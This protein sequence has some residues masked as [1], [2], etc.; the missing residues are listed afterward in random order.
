MN[1]NIIHA[2]RSDLGQKRN[3]NED[4]FILLTYPDN[5]NILVLGAIDGVG[6]YEGGEIATS[7]CKKTI[8]SYMQKPYKVLADS[9][10]KHIKKAV[11]QA[12]NTITENRKKNS[13][14][15]RMSCVVSVAFLDA[16]KERL[17]FAHVGDSRGYIYRK[18]ELIKFTQDH[19]LV[20]Y[21]E[22]RGELT[23]EEAMSHP[24][25]NEISKLLGEKIL[26]PDTDYVQSGT[27]SFYPQDIALF[28]SDGLTDLVDS[29]TIKSI[30][31]KSISLEEKEEALIAEANRLG[32]KDNI[33]VALATYEGESIPL[34]K[35]KAEET[36][37]MG[38]DP[39][40]S[41]TEEEQ[42]I[43]LK[44]QVEKKTPAPQKKNKG[45]GKK[46]LWG[47]IVLLLI[48]AAGYFG[49]TKYMAT[50]KKQT[51]QGR[52]DTIIKKEPLKIV[53]PDLPIIYDYIGDLKEGMK[54][55]QKEGKFGYINEKDSLV[56]PLQYD[57]AES[58][59]EGVAKVKKNGKYGIINKQDFHII[60]I[61]Y[62]EMQEI[63]GDSVYVKKGEKW[64][65]IKIKPTIE[66]EP[67]EE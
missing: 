66:I 24:R 36:V 58:F 7:D 54:V 46:T 39:L 65:Y 12:N 27:H 56:I 30:L 42:S 63:K 33:T 37:I 17:Y 19:S 8:E 21:L 64:S 43:S 10:E 34:N 51:N 5:P 47:V 18:G 52:N 3:N 60:P 40:K 29:Q 14:L 55:V 9:P 15:E 28:C 67:N 23:E 25:R 45:K 48:A 32:G 44:P 31:S 2:Q 41:K 6:G 20:G 16:G 35:T 59:K 57:N 22:E 53:I 49:W 50:E 13:E 4:D 62:K 61:E 26:Q 1:K 38:E 11:I